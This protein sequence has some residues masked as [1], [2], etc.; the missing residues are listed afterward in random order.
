MTNT[1]ATE[2]P[3][4]AAPLQAG[5]WIVRPWRESDAP[6]LH[7]AVAASHEHLGRWLAWAHAGYAQVD[8]VEWI[9]R[10]RRDWLARSTCAFGV[11]AHG[12][13]VLGGAGI[14]RIDALNRVG[15][16]GYWVATGATGQGVAR[17]A[18]RAVAGY[19]F[20]TLGLCR[21]EIVVL[22]D[23]VP[24]RRVAAALG[25]QWECTARHRVQHQGGPA[26]AE[27]YSLLA[28]DLAAAPPG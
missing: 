7:R 10:C 3:A 1:T 17:A 23:N 9:A 20:D 4:E 5:A 8:A 11:F 13:E 21:L 22:P 27:V 12:G 15:N 6:A 18:A 26:A 16:L 2:A 28:V 24:S 25:A 19:G 14:S